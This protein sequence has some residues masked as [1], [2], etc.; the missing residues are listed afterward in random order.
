MNNADLRQ[1]VIAALEFEPSVSATNIGIIVDDGIVTLTGHVAS[2]SEKLNAERTVQSV[3]GV[4]GIAQEIEIRDPAAKKTADDEI[5]HRALNMIAWDA[6]VPDG[7]VKV[8][9]QQGW[10]TLTG[11]LEWD[12]QRRRAEDA[13]HR[14][15]GVIGV[16]DL[17]EISPSVQVSDVKSRIETAFRRS[18]EV[19]AAGIR[20]GVDENKVVLEG[21]V[22][23][24]HERA[25]A[26]RAAWAVPG[27]V[28][29]IDKLAVS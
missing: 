21:R 11:K 4:R 19:E 8:K 14:L 5:A 2:Y 6:A 28:S 17:I 18:A 27:V 13:V 1:H 23:T 26:E 20:V 24:W 25:A 12:F 15:S 22:N 3:K 7:A 16:T 10:V 9:V 29:V